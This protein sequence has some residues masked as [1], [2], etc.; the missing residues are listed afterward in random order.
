MKIFIPVVATAFF[1]VMSVV[2]R[3]QVQGLEHALLSVV[4]ERGWKA[5]SAALARVRGVI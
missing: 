4:V 3:V 1:A 2:I 5:A